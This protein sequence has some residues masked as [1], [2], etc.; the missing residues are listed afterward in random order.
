MVTSTYPL[1]TVVL[2]L[3]MAAL[4]SSLAEEAGFRGYF[5]SA[6]ER[7][8][9]GP[10][11][12]VIMSLVIAPAHG[13]TQGFSSLATDGGSP[14]LLLMEEVKATKRE[15]REQKDASCKYH[16]SMNKKQ[17]ALFGYLRSPFIFSVRRNVPC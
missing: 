17:A 8:V 15:T 4:V 13:L 7:K 6:L 5:Q 10:A 11:A 1:L 14:A 2:V 9:R 12:I 16:D 3:V